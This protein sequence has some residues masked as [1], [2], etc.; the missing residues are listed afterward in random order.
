MWP[1]ERKRLCF[2]NV[3]HIN[4]GLSGLDRQAKTLQES[5]AG[6]DVTNWGSVNKAN[7]IV[8]VDLQMK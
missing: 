4:E 3:V 5:I 1:F 2:I 6:S 7:I 8:Y